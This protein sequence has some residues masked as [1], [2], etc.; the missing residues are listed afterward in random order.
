MLKAAIEKIEAMSHKPQLVE[1]DGHHYWSDR[2]GNLSE[3][4]PEQPRPE[5]ITLNSLAALATFVREEALT[6]LPRVY[7]TVPN[8]LTAE[9][10]GAPDETLRYERCCMYTAKATDVPGWEPKVQLPFEEAIVALRTRFQAAQD[11]D[12]ALRL[13]SNITTGGKITFNDNGVATSIITKKGIDLQGNEAIKPIIRLRPYRTFQEIEQPEGLFL[14][15]VSERAITFIEA[16]G[17]MWKLEARKSI[18]A[19]LAEALAKEI[20]DGTVVLTM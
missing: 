8:H 15:R 19:F 2:E 17:G 1:C 11:S 20:S 6:I 13:L 4:V 16:D 9:C 7:I 5:R 3:I 10:F 14:I 18:Y 12:Y